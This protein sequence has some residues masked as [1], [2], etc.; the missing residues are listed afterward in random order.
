[1]GEAITFTVKTSSNAK[2]LVLCTENGGA[3]KRWASSGNSS[4]SGNVR[5][6]TVRYAFSGAGN[7]S[8]GFKAA[9]A[10][11]YGSIIKVNITVTM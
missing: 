8:I 11:G 3:C 10:G 7:R 1:M 6:W 5:P 2:T 9:S 4:V